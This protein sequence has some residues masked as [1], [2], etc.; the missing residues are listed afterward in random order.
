MMSR[1]ATAARQLE[2]ETLRLLVSAGGAG[3]ADCGGELV[4]SEKHG[5][6][7]VDAGVEQV[8]AVAQNQN[9]GRITDRGP[10]VLPVV[11]P[12]VVSGDSVQRAFEVGCA[13][14]QEKMTGPLASRG[15]VLLP[16]DKP[17]DV[18]IFSPIP[19]ASRD[20]AA[21]GAV[22]RAAPPTFVG[23]ACDQL[24][25]SSPSSDIVSRRSA[26]CAAQ[27][28]SGGVGGGLRAARVGASTPWSGSATTQNASSHGP[29]R[30]R[31]EKVQR[32]RCHRSRQR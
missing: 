16:E 20:D 29:R 25:A 9:D 4:L 28:C 2:P 12:V 15:C 22:Q 26:G 3:H 7:F 21:A 5:R 30:R 17:H 6:A 14:A 13:S 31:L 24:N 1:T 8:V 32:R 19:G 27:E 18:P 23:R 11:L 10:G